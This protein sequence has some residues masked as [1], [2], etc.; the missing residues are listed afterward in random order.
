M[1][2]L[3]LTS[4]SPLQE[5]AARVRQ[6]PATALKEGWLRDRRGLDLAYG[7]AFIALVAS[8]LRRRRCRTRIGPGNVSGASEGWAA[9]GLSGAT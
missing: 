1:K 9:W 2:F 8:S 6:D 7:R 4:G 3:Q 5:R